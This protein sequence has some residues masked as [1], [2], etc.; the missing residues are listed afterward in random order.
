MLIDYEKTLQPASFALASTY[1]ETYFLGNFARS[2]DQRLLL[3][4]LQNL[5][6]DTH[7]HTDLKAYG[8]KE[9]SLRRTI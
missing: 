5:D 7:Q 1:K 3:I 6:C 4:D 2:P 9:D 8:L